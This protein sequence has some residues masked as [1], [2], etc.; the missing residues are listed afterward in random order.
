MSKAMVRGS[1]HGDSVECVM[2][3]EVSAAESVM[4]IMKSVTAKPRN[5]KT[6]SF[7]RQPRIKRER[8]AMLPWPWGDSAAIRR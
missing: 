4:V 7:P 2:C 5:T 3:A 6:I 1:T 8:T